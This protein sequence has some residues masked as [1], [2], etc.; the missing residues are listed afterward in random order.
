MVAYVSPE[1]IERWEKEGRSDIVARLH[2]NNIMWA[3][4]RL[5]KVSGAKVTSC[6]YLGWD[7]TSFSCEIYETRPAVCRGFAPG[8]SEVCSRYCLEE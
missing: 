4:D 3:G 6:F 8:S 1:D 5:V 7:G 2:E